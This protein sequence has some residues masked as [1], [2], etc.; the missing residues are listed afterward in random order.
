M[1]MSSSGND[2]DG[3]VIS[4]TTAAGAQPPGTNYLRQVLNSTSQNNLLQG[5]FIGTD[6][7]VWWRWATPAMVASF[8]GAGSGNVFGGSAI[9]AGNVIAVTGGVLVGNGTTSDAPGQS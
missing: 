3:N 1:S 2:S 8:W 4:G 7:R 9:R 5:N 6:V